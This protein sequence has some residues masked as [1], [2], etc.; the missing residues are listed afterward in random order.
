MQN[1][2]KYPISNKCEYS[3]KEIKRQKIETVDILMDGI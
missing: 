2:A 1:G 3:T